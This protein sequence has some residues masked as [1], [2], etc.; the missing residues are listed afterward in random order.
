MVE[1]QEEQLLEHSISELVSST[2]EPL[3]SVYPETQE[4]QALVLL[5]QAVQSALQTSVQDWESSSMSML[6]PD[7]HR[8]Q[9]A[10][11]LLPVFAKIKRSEQEA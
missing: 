1:E 10:S 2:H 5:E 4:E 8:L 11:P 6:K 9:T 3:L 7:A